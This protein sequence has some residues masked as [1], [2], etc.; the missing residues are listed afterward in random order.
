MAPITRPVSTA[1]PKTATARA[2]GILLFGV[3]FLAGLAFF[4][5]IVG[6]PLLHVV[7][8]RQ[9]RSTSCEIISSRVHSSQDSD[10]STY[11]VEMTYRYSF[12]GRT[13]VGNRYEFLNLSTS[14]YR[15]KA[16]IV[17]RLAPGTRTPCWVN[18]ADAR[19]SVI[20]RGVTLGF[21]FGLIPLLFILIGGAGMYSTA[22]G[23]LPFA[24]AA[25]V[26]TTS[27]ETYAKAV[28]DAEPATLRPAT[29]RGVKLATLV[30]LSVIWN[31]FVAVFLYSVLSRGPRGGVTW[32]FAIFLTPF[33][34]AGIVLVVLSF[35]QALEMSNPRA[36]VTVNRSVVALGDDLRV[37]W[38]MEGSV[39]RLT[40][41]RITLE[42]R[43]EATYTR[44]TDRVTEKNVF[45]TIVVAN[46]TAPAI[47]G[48]GSATVRIPADSMHS[49]TARHNQVK[50][51]LRVRSEVS[52]WPDSDDEFPLTV[53]PRYR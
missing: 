49:F 18:P 12:D 8:A 44:G 11:R 51:A 17:A 4:V 1:A 20:E 38:S 16:A 52:R 29:G 10:G 15:G 24:A 53:A 34:I 45:T 9:W 31:A 35:R 19:E 37:E 5:F 21:L 48:T 14:G 3:F 36:I 32:F 47:A 46:Q 26:A 39:R 40:G 42:A 25:L 22:V 6:R 41:M 2:A 30:S 28:R 33:I 27:E 23:R 13:Y 7:Q 50:W 43:E